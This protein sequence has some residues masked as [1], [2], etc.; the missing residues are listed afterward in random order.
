MTKPILWIPIGLPASSK[1]TWARSLA[2]NWD[3]IFIVSRDSIR[4]MLVGDY[5]K[6]P[7][8]KSYAE[9]IVTD[10]VFYS[11]TELLEK[12]YCVILDETN[13]NQGRRNKFVSSI[14]H[15]VSHEIDVIYNQ[16]FLDV[17]L[18]ECIKRDKERDKT[19]GEKVITRMWKKYIK[20]YE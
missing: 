14:Q 10:I 18:E 6:F 7:F 20:P 8:G 16:D 17:P 2:T 12:G 13:L 9:N 1:S 5:S 11:A 15:A 4:E 3:H 19:I